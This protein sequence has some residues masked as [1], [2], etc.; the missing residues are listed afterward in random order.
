MTDTG[1]YA[2]DTG[3]RSLRGRGLFEITSAGERTVTNVRRIA[4]QDRPRGAALVTAA[5]ILL[6]G[7]AAGLFIVSL[8]A[9]YRYVFTVK[10]Q[11]VPSMIEAAG[12]D[13]GMVV[14]SLL[15]L[16]LAVAGQSAR[17]ER[18]LIIVCAV[19][20]A[21]QNYAAADVTSPRSVAAYVLPP[22]FLALVV[23]R[24]VAV[25]RR[26]VLGDSERSV[27]Q[28]LGRGAAL[29]GL[30]GLRFALAAP[31]TASG[32]RR[33]ILAAAPLPQ[34]APATQPVIAEPAA[35]PA[36]P[37]PAAAPP[38]KRVRPAPLE[39][40][41]AGSAGRAAE[42]RRLLAADPALTKAAIGEQLGTSAR[43][44]RRDL[45]THPDAGSG[46]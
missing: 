39:R 6:A 21:G 11:P 2:A 8:A 12:L 31:S 16:G 38:P 36:R 5:T 13:A 23:D 1:G 4:G 19:A 26:H 14:F 40:K 33:V 29:A 27:W 9:Q 35:Q 18:A 24:V 17:I 46:R 30:Y 32:V 44:I 41:P 10:H 20:S 37:V 7:L 34:A 25:A 43:Q 28:V 42:A 15:A 3:G 45:A 22:L